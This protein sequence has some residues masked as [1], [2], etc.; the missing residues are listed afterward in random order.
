MTRVVQRGVVYVNVRKCET[1]GGVST[2]LGCACEEWD[3][4]R[5]DE[6]HGTLDRKSWSARRGYHILTNALQFFR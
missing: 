2:Y 3:S 5:T 4:P 6:T 1:I